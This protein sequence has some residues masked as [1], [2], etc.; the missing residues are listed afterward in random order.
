MSCIL[1]AFALGVFF[2]AALATMA[3]ILA[4]RRG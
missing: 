3:L 4:W 2:G 1:I